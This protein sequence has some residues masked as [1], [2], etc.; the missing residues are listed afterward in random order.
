MKLEKQHTYHIHKYELPDGSKKEIKLYTMEQVKKCCLD[1]QKIKDAIENMSE[2]DTEGGKC[3]I[4][5]KGYILNLL[6][7]EED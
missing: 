6:G 2:F 7:L 5:S 1:K 3:V 4:C